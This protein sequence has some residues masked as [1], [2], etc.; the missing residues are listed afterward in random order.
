MVTLTP[1]RE[2]VQGHKEGEWQ[3]HTQTRVC[4]TPSVTSVTPNPYLYPL[5]PD[6]SGRR[7]ASPLVR[8]LPLIPAIL[9]DLQEL[10]T[11]CVLRLR[12]PQL[13]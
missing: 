9:L 1:G 8:S 5:K 11:S 3:S 4:L 13:P 6:H 2:R 12:F 7:P 10:S